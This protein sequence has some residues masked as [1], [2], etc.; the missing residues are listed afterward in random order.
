MQ[1]SRIATNS[2]PGNVDQKR[3]EGLAKAWGKLPEKQR[4]E[5]MEELKRDLPP[6]YREAIESYFKKMAQSP[7][8]K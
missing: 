5:A 8:G 1:D 2:G 7:S 6:R 4:A 3:L